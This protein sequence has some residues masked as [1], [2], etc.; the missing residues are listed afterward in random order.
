VS[1]LVWGCRAKRLGQGG[2]TLVELVLAAVVC[3]VVLAGAFGWLWSV[4]SLARV[5]DD[6]AQAETIAA[7][8]A[9]SVVADIRAALA[10]ATPAPERDPARALLLVHDRVAS[11]PEMVTIVWDPARGVLWR[12]ASGTYVAD[13]VD[14]F[15]VRYAL[16]DGRVVAG[17]ELTAEEWTS[18]RS[19][20]VSVTA[21]VGAQQSTIGTWAGV[22][23]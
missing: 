16:P 21:G 18:V 23:S 3:G 11:A 2:F 19:V 13:H 22:G 1:A 20:Y 17:T 8:A 9:R 14:G 7:A 15:A 10:V 5:H 4:G 12:N 6:R